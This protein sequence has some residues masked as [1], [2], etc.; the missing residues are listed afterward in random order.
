MVS[1]KNLQYRLYT[2]ALEEEHPTTNWR[3]AA[4]SL[5][6]YG[7]VE[8]QGTPLKAHIEWRDASEI[9]VLD[10]APGPVPWQVPS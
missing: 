5:L 2:R 8:H 3:S 6:T 9:I 10:R 1:Q 7:R 4:V